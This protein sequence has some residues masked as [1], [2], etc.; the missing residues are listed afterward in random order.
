MTSISLNLRDTLQVPR[1]SCVRLAAFLML[2]IP[3]AAFSTTWIVDGAGSGDFMTIQP[4][5]D[6]AAARD[7]VLVRSGLY[8]GMVSISPDKDGL[9]LIGDGPAENVILTADSVVVR[10]A[11]TDPAALSENVIV[12][13]PWAIYCQAYDNYPP[14]F[15]TVSCNLVWDLAQG[16]SSGCPLLEGFIEADPGFCDAASMNFSV[17]EHSPA[18][19]AP[20]SAGRLGAFGAGCPPCGGEA[21]VPSSWG[22]IKAIYR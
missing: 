13:S 10:I 4:A 15:P 19:S 16:I 7:S 12:G 6:A 22:A 18:L 11:Q 2:C 1:P 21:A 5:I 14:S 3:A 17:C 20:C 9:W 8:Q